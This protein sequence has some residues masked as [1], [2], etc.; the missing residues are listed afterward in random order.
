MSLLDEGNCFLEMIRSPQFAKAVE[1]MKAQQSRI[2]SIR[3]ET[4]Q[5]YFMI[6]HDDEPEVIE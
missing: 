1:H 3:S 5:L 4:G 2:E 6:G